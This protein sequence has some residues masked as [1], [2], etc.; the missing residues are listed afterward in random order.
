[1][2]KTKGVLCTMWVAVLMHGWTSV[3][4]ADDDSGKVDPEA[5]A[6]ACVVRMTRAANRCVTANDKDADRTVAQIRK[7][8]AAGKVRQARRV[9][10]VAI[11]RI[12]N[13]SDNTVRYIRRTSN[14]CVRILLKMGEKKLAA[15]VLAVRRE[16]VTRV[17]DSQ[18]RAI[19]RIRRAFPSTGNTE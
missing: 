9:A 8:L 3:A 15:R 2:D 19:A 14:R 17:R 4:Q 7:L 10:K 13:R 1:M 16:R 6:K 5:L 11:R 18:A 12:N